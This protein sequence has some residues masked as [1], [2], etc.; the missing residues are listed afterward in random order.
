MPDPGCLTPARQT[1]AQATPARASLSTS[2]YLSV[3]LTT[4]YLDVKLTVNACRGL[5]N[6]GGMQT[7]AD[8]QSAPES[9][10]CARRPH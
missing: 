8:S 9:T 1:A 5:D 6:V 4:D 10:K 2:S 3:S 7:A